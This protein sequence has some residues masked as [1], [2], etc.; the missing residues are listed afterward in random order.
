MED[1]A[2]AR[3]ELPIQ[4]RHALRVVKV[5]V[6]PEHASRADSREMQHAYSGLL[7]AELLIG[8]LC[9]ANTP[10][11]QLKKTSRGAASSRDGCWQPLGCP[12]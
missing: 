12:P 4:L 2:D 8:E 10:A 5:Q 11:H 9:Q 1:A 3:E 6:D 7:D